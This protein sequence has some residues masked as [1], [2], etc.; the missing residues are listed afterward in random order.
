VGTDAEVIVRSI[1]DPDAFG[2]IFERHAATIMAYARRR[3]GPVAGEEV[4]AQTFLVAFQRRSQ[5]NR[6]YESARPWLLGIATNVIRHHLRDER[7]HLTKLGK[8][9][10]PGVAEP[11]EDPDRADALR[12]RPT[13]TAALLELAPTDRDTFLLVV[14]GEL[15][16]E[17]TARELGIPVGTVRSRVHRARNRLRE[18]LRRFVAIPGEP[19]ETE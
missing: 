14:L 3:V 15:T 9:W 19:G 18:R 11:V 8:A 7:D 2:V 16:Y 12:L 13:L 17:E 10:S 6:S 4:A 1:E 5:F